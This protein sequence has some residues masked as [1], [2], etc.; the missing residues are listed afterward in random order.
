MRQVIVDT[1]TTG[2]S[3]EEDRIIEIG[4]IE[5]IN[6]TLTGR[7]FH[8]Y[9]NPG[10]SI[11]QEAQAVH[12]ITEAFLQ[13]K[14]VFSDRAEKLLAF[15]SDAELIIHNAPFD[16]GFIDN[17][18]RRCDQKWQKL[19]AHCQ[20][21][22]SLQ[23][24]RQRHPGQRNSLDALCKRYGIDNTHRELHGALLDAHLLA[25]VWL[26]MTG[27]QTSFFDF[28][29]EVESR[30]A[31]SLSAATPVAERTTVP[32]KVIR[33]NAEECELHQNS[34]TEMKKI[35]QCLWEEM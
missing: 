5:M 2:L 32:L 21:T 27:G 33:A 34:L 14:P 25:K 31:V 3:P 19:T 13:D 8:Q 9:L 16:T 29:S 22:D 6:R 7:R 10:R 4:C 20:I 23:L 28:S 35:G 1:E 15:L 17:E 30:T 11:S 24:A 26:A 12:G 18:F